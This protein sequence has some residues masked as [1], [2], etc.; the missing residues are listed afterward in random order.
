MTKGELAGGGKELTNRN[1]AFRHVGME[2]D[3]NISFLHTFSS[4]NRI[5]FSMVLFK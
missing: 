1:Q 2:Q 3:A 4:G 5:A